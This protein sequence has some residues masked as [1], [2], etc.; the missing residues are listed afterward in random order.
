[1][2]SQRVS[3]TFQGVHSLWLGFLRAITAGL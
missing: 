3:K 1:K 2:I